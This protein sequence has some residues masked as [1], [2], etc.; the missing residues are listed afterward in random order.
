M[1]LRWKEEV[2]REVLLRYLCWQWCCKRM[3][4][5]LRHFR[6]MFY[7][8]NW[9]PSAW[10]I[11]NLQTMVQFLDLSSWMCF[12]EF[13]QS[14]YRFYRAL[15]HELRNTRHVYSSFV[16]IWSPWYSVQNRLC[17][18]IQILNIHIYI[19]IQVCIHFIYI[20]MWYYMC[21]SK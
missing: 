16:C 10:D 11:P 6:C 1:V 3:E 13:L 18:F 21:I 20:Y 7:V 2:T 4:G 12:L 8:S 15:E 17:I 19:Y 5:S 14:V 9:V